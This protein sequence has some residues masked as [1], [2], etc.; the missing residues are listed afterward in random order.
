MTR[1]HGRI[2]DLEIEQP[3]GRIEA[4][5]LR[6]PEPKAPPALAELLRLR[7]ESLEP[8]A[9]QRPDRLFE[10]QAHELVRGVVAARVLA[11]KDIQ[12][13]DDFVPFARNLVF[14]ETLVDRAEL[15]H[16]QVAVIDIASPLRRCLERQSVDDVGHD[17][18][19]QSDSQ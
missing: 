16:A 17:P 14:Q 6:Q 10:N 1:S 4:F 3:A 8:G 15:L 5:Q 2:T 7:G 18:I 9:Y 19:A 13:D 12:A 11:C